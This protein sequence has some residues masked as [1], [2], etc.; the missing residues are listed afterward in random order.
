MR[1]NNPRLKSLFIKPTIACTADCI[2]CR[3]RKALYRKIRNDR[4]LTLPEYVEFFNEMKAYD[5]DSLHISGGEPTLYPD[6]PVLIREG[7]KHGW[8]VILNTNGSEI[9]ENLAGKLIAARLDAVILSLQSVK[10]ETNDFLR[11]RAGHWKRAVNGLAALM[12]CRRESG[13]RLLVTTQT[14]LTK[15]NFRELP[16]ILE[17]AGEIG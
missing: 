7:K 16:Q 6:L 8:F 4:M 3:N 9:S 13:S 5:I 17:Y 12:N 14:I 10:P 11:R 2:H 15:L 1:R